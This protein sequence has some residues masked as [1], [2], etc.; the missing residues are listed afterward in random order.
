MIRLPDKAKQFLIV[1]AKLSVVAAAFYFI[2]YRLKSDPALT[3][4]LFS[5]RLRHQFNI[6]NITLL[7]ALSFLNRFL[8]IVK[9]KNLVA[10]IRPISLGTAASHVMGAL[11]VS[12]F[13]PAGVGEYGAKAL[14]FERTLT[15]KIV[16]LNLISN[17]AQMFLSVFFGIF[18]LLYLNAKFGFITTKTVAA[19]FVTLCILAIISFFIRG[20]SI[21]GYSIQRLVK[22]LSEVPRAIHRKNFLLST[23]RY[24]TFSHQYLLLFRIL[25][26]NVDYIPLMAAIA[27]VYFLASSVPTF[28]FLDFAVKGSVAVF[29]FAFFAVDDW[30]PVFIASLMWLLNV[31]IPVLIGS[32]FVLNF[33]PQWKQS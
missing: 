24:L 9:W 33:K 25:D 13:T 21:R 12:I 30:I 5:A 4:D 3:S 1:V 15:K 19:I 11:T 20:F 6:A 28:Q 17:G 31:V 22:K 29:F 32:Y 23:L 18:G 16:F 7:L 14:F 2:W 26:V 27:A 10:S 8:E